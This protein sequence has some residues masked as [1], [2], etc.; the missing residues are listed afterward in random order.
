MR[1]DAV[2]YC[3]READLSAQR[4]RRS[5]IGRN[6]PSKDLPQ[7]RLY[8]FSRSVRGNHFLACQVQYLKTP[9][10]TREISKADL[11]RTVSVLPNLR[12]VDLPDDFYNDDPSSNTLRQE[13]QTQCGD[14]R[15]MKYASGAE[16]S[17]Q[18]LAQAQQ[19]PNLE[20][21]ELLHIAM[22][23]AVVLDVFTS[24][25]AL[26]HVKLTNP[27]F[28]DDS[29][30]GTQ[31]TSTSPFPPL[32]VLEI[33]NAPNVSAK[34]LLTYLSY[35]EVKEAL[36]SLTL[37]DTNILPLDHSQILAAAPSLTT[38]HVVESVS[39][40]TPQSQL[41]LLASCSLRVLHYEI[42]STDSSLRGLSDP[43]DSYY[44][45]LYVMYSVKKSLLRSD[46]KF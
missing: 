27:H 1:I 23:P 24:L 34:G 45:Y 26:R 21:L 32:A 9:Y 5:L 38:L 15:Q 10:L 30:F 13:L 44:F 11:A 39:R 37:A 3:D 41:P 46:S 22:D 31:R 12:Y 33:R 25:K 19:W 35:P 29:V 8:L 20:T 6:G 42:S 40:A 7:E 14:I 18:R 43:S 36:R 28:L 2:H 17:F 16:V 4:Q